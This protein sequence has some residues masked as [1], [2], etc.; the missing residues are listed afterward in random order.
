M[1]DNPKKVLCVEDDPDMMFLVGMVLE[2]P[3][4]HVTEAGDGE[5]ALGI[6]ERD[7]PDIALVDYMLPGIDGIE[8]AERLRKRHPE[9]PIVMFSAHP[10][11]AAKAVAH[12]DIDAFVPKGN[13]MTVDQALRELL[14]ARTR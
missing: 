8:V 13:V 1:L 3:E 6:I 14:A 9:C 11:V 7:P 4:W 10:M 2:A 12:P 5:T